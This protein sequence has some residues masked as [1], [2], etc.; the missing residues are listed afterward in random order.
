[1][2]GARLPLF[3]LLLVL[4][5]SLYGQSF[6]PSAVYEVTGTELNKLESDLKT[7]QSELETL[8]IRNEQLVKDSEKLRTE[9]AALSKDSES[10][11]KALTELQAQLKTASSSWQAS[12]NEAL[13]REAWA[14]A[15]GFTVGALAVALLWAF[16]LL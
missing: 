4:S 9:L 15:G 14:A 16:H 7:A 10:K 5:S 12:Q 3:S 6:E 8:R 13:S 2:C 11:E 1:M